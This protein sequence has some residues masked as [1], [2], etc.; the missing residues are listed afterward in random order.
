MMMIKIQMSNNTVICNSSH[1]EERDT[2]DVSSQLMRASQVM[3][4]DSFSYQVMHFFRSFTCCHYSESS[5]PPISSISSLFLPIHISPLPTTS[6]ISFSP[7]SS[8]VD[9][10]FGKCGILEV[11]VSKDNGSMGALEIDEN[12]HSESSR[13]SM[14]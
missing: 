3:H 6:P 11:R 9:R 5:S 14:E 10:D 2:Y 13:W 12:A 7:D 1:L 8:P 4:M